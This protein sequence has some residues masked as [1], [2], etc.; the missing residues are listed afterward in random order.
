MQLFGPPG[1]VIRS[2]AVASRI[3]AKSLSKEAAIRADVVR[4]WQK[5]RAAGLSTDDAAAAVGVSRATIYRGARRPEPLSRR[6]RR[7]RRPQW[8]PA[9]TQAVEDLPSDNP[10]R[11]KRKIRLADPPRRGC[12]RHPP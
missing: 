11:G 1:H 5:A 7:V 3:A 2:A 10:I 4:R 8:S 9:L 12:G 6:P